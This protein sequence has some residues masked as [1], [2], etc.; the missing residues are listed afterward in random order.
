[1]GADLMKSLGPDYTKST[2][3]HLMSIADGTFKTIDSG[4]Y[5]MVVHVGNA[6]V[7]DGKFMCDAMVY[8]DT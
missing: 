8:Q 5:Q 1:M 2:K 7:K 4:I 3:I 6:F